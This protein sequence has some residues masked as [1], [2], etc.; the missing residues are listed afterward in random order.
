MSDVVVIGGGMAGLVCAHDLQQAGLEVTLLEASDGLGGRVRSDR[1][2]GFVLDRGFQILL[3]AYPQVR[4]RLDLEA[5]GLAKFTPGAIVRTASGSH[6][7]SDPLRRPADA[8]RTLLAPVGSPAD[9]L[10]LAS[11]VLDVSVPSAGA[12]LRRP[13]RSTAERLRAAGFSEEFVRLFWRPLFAGIQLDPELE[14]SARR[15]E[16]VLRMLAMGAT[17]L[18]RDGIGAV[19]EQLAARLIHTDVR[20]NAPVRTVEP[21][22]VVLAGGE[23]L[24]AR[25]V[26]VATEGPAAHRLLGDSVPDPG[27]RPVAACWFSLARAP[28]EAPMLLLDGH[29]G[30]PALNAVVISQVQPA[31]APV[32]R[33]L[34]VAAVPGPRAL[35]G[36]LAEQVREQ[37][38]RWMGV[39]TDELTPLRTDVI[40]HGQ[41][42]QTPPLSVRRR[43]DLGQ[44]M[45]VCGDHR[46]T[47]SLQGAMFSGERTAR[48]VI[49]SLRGGS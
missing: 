24:A 21:G 13:D 31:Y 16:I 26:V 46:D 36:G 29:S 28:L 38:S 4:A 45:F 42:L 33:S 12:V 18:P 1:V 34:L 7:L 32:G 22:A 14:V 23:R 11:L 5:L 41:P 3:T 6:R 27:S 47:A 10:R 43:V 9:K 49:Q 19:A 48:A 44:G 40:A 37:L 39:P 17:G 2:D 30:G 15:F 35:D 25:A 20:L 8:L